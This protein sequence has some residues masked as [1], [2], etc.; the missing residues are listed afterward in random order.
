LAQAIFGTTRADRR[1]EALDGG[2]SKGS[3]AADCAARRAKG[4]ERSAL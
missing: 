3:W 4:L 1:G 2:N